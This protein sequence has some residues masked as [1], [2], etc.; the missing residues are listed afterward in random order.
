MCM[1]PSD[2]HIS[3]EVE[4][5]SSFIKTGIFT[6]AVIFIAGMAI[7]YSQKKIVQTSGSQYGNIIHEKELPIYCV[8]TTEAKVALSFDAAWGNT[9]YGL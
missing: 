8:D 3:E 9:M 6:L 7:I 2:L 4:K 1:K 5:I